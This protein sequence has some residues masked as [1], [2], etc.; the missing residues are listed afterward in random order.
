MPELTIREY[1][2]LRGISP[3][4]VRD[5]IGRGRIPHKRVMVSRETAVI[6]VE[7]VELDKLRQE[8]LKRLKQARGRKTS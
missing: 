3:Q 4:A 2:D 6:E 8:Q 7:A 5:A 1:A